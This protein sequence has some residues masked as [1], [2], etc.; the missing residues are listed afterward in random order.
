MAATS[1]S[2]RGPPKRC[3]DGSNLFNLDGSVNWRCQLDGCAPLEPVC[4]PERLDICF[5]DDGNETGECKWRKD[6]CDTK[7]SCVWLWSGCDGEW[8]YDW[9]T[10]IGSCTTVLK[11]PNFAPTRPLGSCADMHEDARMSIPCGDSAGLI[12]CEPGDDGDA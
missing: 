9:D 10:G 7:L 11:Q 1:E 2:R 4:W 3:D 5:D 6:T 8:N 12:T